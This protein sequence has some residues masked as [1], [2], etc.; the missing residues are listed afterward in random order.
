MEMERVMGMDRYGDRKV[1]LATE[2]E[3]QHMKIQREMLIQIGIMMQ[4]IVNMKTK[5][6]RQPATK[7][8]TT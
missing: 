8:V 3:K 5:Y 4:K 1:E 6:K 2:M 7:H